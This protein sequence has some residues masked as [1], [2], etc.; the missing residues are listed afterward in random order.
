MTEL[1]ANPHSPG[2]SQFLIHGADDG[3]VKI[4]MGL[5][6][7]TL[8]LPQAQCAALFQG[9]QQNIIPHLQDMYEG[10]E[11]PPEA[12]HKKCLWVRSEGAR[13]TEQV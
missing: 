6:D 11:L 5:D 9:S 7:E 4:D 12:T 8:R 13:A 1:I 3:R 10:S 2:K